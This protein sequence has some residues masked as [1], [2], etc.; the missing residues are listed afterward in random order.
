MNEK[1][2]DFNE[3]TGIAALLIHA[4][5]IDDN[6]TNKEKNLISDFLK[7]FIENEEKIQKIFKNA[8]DLEKNSN[9][10]ITFTNLIKKN[11]LETKTLIV[12]QLWKIIIS[13][14]SS[15][16]YE[17]NLMRRICGLIYFP[18]KLSGEVK[19]QIQKEKS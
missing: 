10:L 3:L 17:A 12:K 13:D 8:E 9:Q 16:D 4:A 11:S 19:M 1:K 15:D 18:D 5:K 6:Y 7:S 2:L 14:N